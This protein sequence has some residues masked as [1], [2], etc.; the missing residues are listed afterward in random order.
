MAHSSLILESL[1]DFAAK[2]M[3]SKSRATRFVDGQRLSGP[4]VPLSASIVTG[5]LTHHAD[6]CGAAVDHIQ[7]DCR[8][9]AQI[10]DP[11][12]TNWATVGYPHNHRPAVAGICNQHACAK[13]QS[14]M[15]RGQLRGP[16]HFTACG[17]SDAIERSHPIFSLR[18]TARE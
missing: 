16:T 1:D 8:G 18:C 5:L 2:A 12:A 17:A 3:R 11:S 7:S 15:R 6:H 4:H 13:R 9:T 10:N 14:A